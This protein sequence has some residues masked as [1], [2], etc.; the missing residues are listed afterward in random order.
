VRNI[1]PTSHAASALK[2]DDVIMRFDGIDISNDGTIPFRTGE[3]I[4]FSYL[5]SNKYIGDDCSLDIWRGG[6]KVS[7]SVK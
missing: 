1:N 7:C 4:A 6:E 2:P 5:I 3:R